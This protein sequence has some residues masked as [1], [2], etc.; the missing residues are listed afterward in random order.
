MIEAVRDV[1]ARLGWDAE[2][3]HFESFGPKPTADDRPVR[4]HLARSEK[5][6][7]VPARRSILDT[8][9]DAAISVPHDCKRGECSL[10]V[11]RSKSD[12]LTLD[13]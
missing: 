13:L 9:L 3:I 4:V 12:D 1:A 2:Q 6:F 8:L 5:T 11:T 10:C 7:T